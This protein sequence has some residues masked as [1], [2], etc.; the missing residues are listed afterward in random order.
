M[1]RAK[2]YVLD[3]FAEGRYQGNQLAVFTE[4]NNIPENEMQKIAREINFSET[5][6][7][8]DNND[9]GNG[10]PVRI[11][12]PM[13]EVDFAGHPT[14]GTAWIIRNEILKTNERLINLNLKIG[15]IPVTFNE[16]EILWMKQKEPAFGEIYSAKLLSEILKIK[17]SDIDDRFPVQVV[18]TGLP[19]II[20]P[21]KTLRAIKQISIEKEK[22]FNFLS[23]VGPKAILTFCSETYSAQNQLNVRVFVD[24]FGIPE[25]PATGSG[26]GCL[27]GYLVKHLYFN[28]DSID[29]TCEQGYEIQRP[30][31]LYLKASSAEH[32]I[33]V[34]VGGKVQLVS[35]GNWI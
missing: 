3:V 17:V 7:V 4:L 22:Y 30:S 34:E 9:S 33:R 26:N 23:K 5:T 19:A 12:T 27:A 15:T 11:F 6:F 18:S 10:F 1:Y 21:V 24:Y 16:N 28:K 20:V 35:S 13:E 8:L 25:D 29:I 14:L 31:I 32:T 2:Y